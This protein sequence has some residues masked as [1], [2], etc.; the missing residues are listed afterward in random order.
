MGADADAIRK[1]FA[2][3]CAAL[4]LRSVKVL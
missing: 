4:G 3:M 2:D 1:L